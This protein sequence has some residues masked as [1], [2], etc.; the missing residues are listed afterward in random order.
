MKMTDTSKMKK[1]H[2]AWILDAHLDLA[3]NALEWNRDLRQ[4]ISEIRKREKGMTDKLDREKGVVSLPALRRGRIGIVVGRQIP[5]NVR[6]G[7]EFPGWTSHLQAWDQPQG[8][9][10]WSRRMEERAGWFRI[11]IMMDW[12]TNGKC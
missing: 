5:G 3:M 4:P 9:F 7:G 10:A 6:P 8:H 2:R 12:A 1:H 11:R